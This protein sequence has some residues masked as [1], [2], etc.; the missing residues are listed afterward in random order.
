MEDNGAA[1]TVEQAAEYLGIHA[2]TVRQKVREGYLRAY[3]LPGRGRR[4]FFKRADLWAMM[5]EH[6]VEADNDE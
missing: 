1:M 5:E 4:F 2:D 6:N 3:H